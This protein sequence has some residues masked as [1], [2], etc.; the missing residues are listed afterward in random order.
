[1]I[2]QAGSVAILAHPVYLEN[3]ELT[4]EILQLG[5]D[6]IEVTNQNMLKYLKI[7]QRSIS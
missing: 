7:S 5:L 4:E 6:G 3:M 2:H 1:M